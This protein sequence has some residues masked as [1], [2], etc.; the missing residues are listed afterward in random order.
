MISAGT[1]LRA[2]RTIWLV[3]LRRKETL[4]AY[5]NSRGKRV[6]PR[7]QTAEDAM[8]EAERQ[9]PEFMAVSA[10]KST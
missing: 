10:R 1:L 9:N 8:A 6:Y 3:E 4:N 5:Q 7:A 2:P